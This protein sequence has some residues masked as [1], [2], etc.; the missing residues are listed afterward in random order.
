MLY[1]QS[2]LSSARAATALALPPLVRPAVTNADDAN[3][4]SFG[5]IARGLG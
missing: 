1:S 4:G 3:D 5:Q 2:M